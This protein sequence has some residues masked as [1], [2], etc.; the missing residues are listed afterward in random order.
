MEKKP[1]HPARRLRHDNAFMMDLISALGLALAI[2][3]ILFA[4]FPQ[5]MRKAMFEAAHSP[6]ERMRIIGIA[7]AVLGLLVVWFARQFG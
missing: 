7:C 6:I 1:P 3:G 2:E 4:A 5:G